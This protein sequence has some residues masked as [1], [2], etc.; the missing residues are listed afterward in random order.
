MKHAFWARYGTI[1]TRNI[2]YYLHMF[3]KMMFFVSEKNESQI[4]VK[5]FK[6]HI[7]YD[8]I[9]TSAKLVVF[10]TKL[11]VKKVCKYI[12]TIFVC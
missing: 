8:L 5:F 11:P 2:A 1:N 7:A 4:I 9:P 12:V 6:Y 3:Y 10:D